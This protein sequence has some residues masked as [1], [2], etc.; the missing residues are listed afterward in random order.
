MNAVILSRVDGEG[1]PAE[2]AVSSP[3]G[4][5]FAVYA[6]QDDRRFVTNTGCPQ[7]IFPFES[8]TFART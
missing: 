5:S 4:G 7:A 1:P 2:A 6:A 3:I 8:I